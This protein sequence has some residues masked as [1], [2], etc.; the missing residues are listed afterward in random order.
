MTVVA[1]PPVSAPAVH[2]IRITDDGV[3]PADLVVAP[4]DAIVWRNGGRNRHTVT[5]DDGRF[6]SQTLFTGDTFRIT[7]P[8]RPGPTRTTASSTCTSAAA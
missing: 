5:A 1:T 3:I 7:A 4:S 2:R 6:G 8:A